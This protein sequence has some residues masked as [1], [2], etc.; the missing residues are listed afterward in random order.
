MS[1]DGIVYVPEACEANAGCRVHIA[2]H[3]CGQNRTV[4]GDAF[5]RDSGYAR[6]ADTNNII[7]LFPQTA[8]TPLNPQGCWD[9]WG[10]TGAELSD[11]RRPADHRRLPH[12]GAAL[13]AA[14]ALLSMSS[15]RGNGAHGDP[16]R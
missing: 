5:A 8:T 9:W 11:P 7:V 15:R 6:W 2:F 16:A 10:Y 3:G 4:V 13:R 12:A 14:H 1:D